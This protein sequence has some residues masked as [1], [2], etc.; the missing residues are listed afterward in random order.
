MTRPDPMPGYRQPGYRQ[1][2]ARKPGSRPAARDLVA[3]VGTSV[4]V[5]QHDPGSGGEVADL[6]LAEGP[7]DVGERSD[8]VLA[9]GCTAEQAPV[10]VE[11]CGRSGAA[12]VVLRLP[13]AEQA[14][15]RAAARGAGVLLVG[16]RP[17]I[18]WAHLVW[19]LRGVLD[20]ASAPASPA[21]G[22]AAVHND[23]FVL[24][25]AAAA[26]VDA[27]VTIEDSRSRVLAYSSGQGVT[28]PARVDTIVGR[29]VPPEVVDHYRARGVF[30]RLARS[31]EPFLVPAGPQGTLP[32]LVVPV[33]A[34]GEWLGSIWAVVTGPAPDAVVAEL[35][36]A[37]AVLAL[38]LLRVRAQADVAR[39]NEVA[40]V[41]AA[42][43]SYQ[44]DASGGLGSAHLPAA[45]WRVAALAATEANPQRRLELWEA[46]LRRHGWLDPAVADLEGTVFAVL[47]AGAATAAEPGSWTWLERVAAQ[48]RT[49]DH[50]VRV[51]AGAVVGTVAGLPRSR[52]QAAELLELPVQAASPEPPVA[53]TFEHA[54]APVAVHRAVDALDPV[55]EAS[56][57]AAPVRVLVEHDAQ[58]G[59]AYARTLAA[60]LDFPGEP[61]R[62]AAALH[63]HVNTLRHRMR[64]IAALVE[65]AGADLTDPE[66]RLALRL[67][68]AT[69]AG[70]GCSWP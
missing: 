8:L 39:R 32:R 50:G 25:D 19:M 11:G 40:A 10:L 67:H 36:N 20:R 4:F 42:L 31:D 59:S 44:P 69:V 23:L 46:V 54:W 13:L 38:H 33:R 24:A 43:H 48:A 14:D 47:G 9:A 3:A 55:D 7:A 70:C 21:A 53:T 22:D 1:P 68:L 35:R 17:E 45:P 6:V 30:R 63:V 64:R 41:R 16:V 34:G 12:G 60:W 28:D 18:P 26:I 52:S 2:G 37:A 57:P 65:E 5:V 56:G 61:Q 49:D 29:R 51:T 27:P 15:V 62:A 58:H 66:H